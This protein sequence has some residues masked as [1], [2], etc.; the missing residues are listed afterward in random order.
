MVGAPKTAIEHRAEAGNRLAR[1]LLDVL[2]SPREQDRYIA[3]SQIGITVASPSDVGMYGEP[4]VAALPRPHLGPLPFV[5]SAALSYA[6]ALAV[7]TLAHIVFGEIV[8][9]SVVLQHGERVARLAY[10][11]IRV[12]LLV[13]YPLVRGLTGAA[14]LCLRLVGVRRR[15]N[16][17][18]QSYTPEELQLIVKESEEGGAIRRSPGGCCASCSSSAT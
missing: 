15:E 8:P 11:P 9:K 5:G 2:E 10:W 7:L 3:T 14:S 16:T 12:T 18:E 6:I 17:L 1:R 4:L 13:L